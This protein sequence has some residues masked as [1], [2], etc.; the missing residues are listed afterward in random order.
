MARMSSVQC[1][2]SRWRCER[3]SHGFSCWM[4]LA[5]SSRARFFWSCR[6]SLCAGRGGRNLGSSRRDCS[7]PQIRCRIRPEGVFLGGHQGET[8]TRGRGPPMTRPH[9]LHLTPQ[10]GPADNPTGRGCPR[11]A[12][13]GL[14]QPGARGATS[15]PTSAPPPVSGPT[16]QGAPTRAVGPSD[17]PTPP[18]PGFRA[19]RPHRGS[20]AN[21]RETGGGARFSVNPVGWWP[22]PLDHLDEVE[23]GCVLPR[24]T[25]GRAAHSYTSEVER[26][27]TRWQ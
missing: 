21:P 23:R 2:T 8:T 3:R 26:R 15:A 17:G 12:C 18:S 4:L 5:L 9:H 27:W 14:S 1:G 24:Q 7:R 16:P 19:G 22:N 20:G 6:A 10:L 11:A 13:A 25:R